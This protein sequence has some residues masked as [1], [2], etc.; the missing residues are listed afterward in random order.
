MAHFPKHLTRYNH[1]YIEG[2]CCKVTYNIAWVY[3]LNGKLFPYISCTIL[4]HIFY[5]LVSDSSTGIRTLRSFLKPGRP[6]PKTFTSEFKSNGDMYF[7]FIKSSWLESMC[8]LFGQTQQRE[9]HRVRSGPISFGPP[10]P[11]H[12][13]RNLLNRRWTGSPKFRGAPSSRKCSS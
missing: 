5:D 3:L 9:P 7:E 11:T 1:S 2:D 13:F 4:K 8:F 6:S 12:R 10:Q